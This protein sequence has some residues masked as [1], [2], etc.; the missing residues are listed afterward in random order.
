MKRWCQQSGIGLLCGLW[1]IALAA[2]KPLQEQDSIRE[3]AREHAQQMFSDEDNSVN[4]T[5]KPLDRRLKLPACDRPLEAYDSPNGINGGRGVVGVRCPGTSPWKLYVPVEISV[6]RA[7]VVAKRPLAKGKLLSANDLTLD[8]VD[9]SRLRKAYFDR[10]EDAVGHRLKRAVA[11]D[12]VLHTKLVER[13]ELV[14]RG[15][16]VEI[17]ANEPGLLVSMRGKALDD[18]SLGDRIRVRNLRSGRVV[19]ATVTGRG[20]VQVAP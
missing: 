14:A 20:I 5:A 9:V 17:M 7:V 19:A 16:L 11:A 10:I 6:Y 12:G 8:E 2:D 4:V 3:T 1:S 15:S 13:P 18:G